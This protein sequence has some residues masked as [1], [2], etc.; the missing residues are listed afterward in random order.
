LLLVT[1]AI[2]INA[3]EAALRL[4][5][6]EQGS[7]CAVATQASAFMSG[8]PGTRNGY[9]AKTIVKFAIRTARTK[10]SPNHFS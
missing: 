7:E 2:T 9:A 4:M 8:L 1:K 10:R 3:A 5:A 6:L